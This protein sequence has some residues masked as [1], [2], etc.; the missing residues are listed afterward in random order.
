MPIAYCLLPNTYRLMPMIAY[1]VANITSV[2]NNLTV[3]IRQ[4]H[5]EF[6]LSPI[7]YLYYNVVD[8]LIFKGEVFDLGRSSTKNKD[9]LIICLINYIFSTCIVSISL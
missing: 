1:I 7:H 8:G 4:I 9:S 5:T 6:S 2:L 3:L